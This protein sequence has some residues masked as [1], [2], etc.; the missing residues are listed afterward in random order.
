MADLVGRHLE[1]PKALSGELLLAA[2]LG[3]E[4]VLATSASKHLTV[5]GK[6][7]ALGE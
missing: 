4:V 1:I 7:E 5:L 3:V 6:L 2:C